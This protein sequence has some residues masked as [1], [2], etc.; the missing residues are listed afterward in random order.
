MIHDHIDNIA[1]YKGMDA[2]IY[3]GLQTLATLDFDGMPL[4]RHDIDGDDLFILV[5][6]YN[7]KVAATCRPEAHRTYIDIQYVLSGTELMGVTHLTPDMPEV[8]ARPDGDIWFYQGKVDFLTMQP[9]YFCVL[10]PHDAHM[11]SVAVDD[12]PTPNRK[13]I[14]KVKYD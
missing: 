11:P 13:I 7:S 9:K 3:R 14:V 5:Q 8:E 1:A 2:R 10:F 12:I 4:G 6:E